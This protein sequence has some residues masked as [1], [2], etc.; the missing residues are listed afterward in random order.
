MDNKELY[1]NAFVYPSQQEWKDITDSF[2][3]VNELTFK[4]NDNLIDKSYEN[5]IY[6]FIAN[7]DI[8]PWVNRLNNKL[9]KLRFSYVLSK[10]YKLKGIPDIN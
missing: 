2:P 3:V 5:E 9:S 8:L 10:Y 4:G 1:A 6:R 7:N